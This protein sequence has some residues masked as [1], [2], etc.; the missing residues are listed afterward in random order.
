MCD[1]SLAGIP[2]RLAAEGEQLMVYRFYTGARGLTSPNTSLWRFWSKQTPAVCVPPGAR[3]LLRDIPKTLQQHFD[4]QATE[5][6]TFAQLNA[7]AY[8][9]RD[10]VQITNGREFLM[11]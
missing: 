1:Y 5:K 10:A 3:L 4:L 11:T 6:V 2:N 7:E 9:F 8:E